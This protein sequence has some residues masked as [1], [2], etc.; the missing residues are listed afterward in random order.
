MKTSDLVTLTVCLNVLAGGDHRDKKLSHSHG[1]NKNA[2]GSVHS[3]T[4]QSPSVTDLSV[5]LLLK[6]GRF[7]VAYC[8]MLGRREEGCY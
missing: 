3:S 1:L 8:C 7:K 2:E 6:C 5:R 4:S